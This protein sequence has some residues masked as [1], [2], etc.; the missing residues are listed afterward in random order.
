LGALGTQ[1]RVVDDA[2]LAARSREVTAETVA[3]SAN[4][5]LRP[6]IYGLAI[7]LAFSVLLGFSARI[8]EYR[9]RRQ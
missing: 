2:T 1:T 5:G 9:Y 8:N 4:R 6:V 7:L 3:A